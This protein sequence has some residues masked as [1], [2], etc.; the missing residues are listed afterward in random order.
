MVRSENFG[1]ILAMIVATDKQGVV[2]FLRGQGVSVSPSDDVTVVVRALYTALSSEML[3]DR[4][5]QWA[6]SRYQ[7]K[8]NFTGSYKGADGNFDPMATQGSGQEFDPLS[9]QM[10][11]NLLED[12]FANASGEFNPMDT[13]SGRF[14]PMSTQMGTN[15]KEDRFANLVHESN[16]SGGFN[17][18][19]TQSGGFNPME[20][21][22][23]NFLKS[24][25]TK[26][27]TPYDP[28]TGLGG[29]K[30]GNFFRSID[31]ADI[32]DKAFEFWKTSET[33][34]Q[35]RDIINAEIKAKELELQALV[36]AGKL[37]SQQMA[38]QLA[39]LKAQKNAPQSSVILYVIGGVVLLGALGTAIY[40]AT[41]KK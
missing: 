18:M 35:Q 37:S 26:N 34:K 12:N 28:Q 33:G 7:N 17:P 40:F 19:D 29:S 14:T 3:K 24:D 31:F 23:A 25:K 41:R 21:Q 13:Q 22:Y 30:A 8:S 1:E 16:A 10:G 20:S 15:L 38:D 5:V 11:T 9:S 27:Y 2:S 39:L 6:E 32:G 36:E 4:F